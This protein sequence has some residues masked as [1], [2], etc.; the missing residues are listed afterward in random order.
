[1]YRKLAYH[2]LQLHIFLLIQRYFLYRLLFNF[3]DSSSFIGKFVEIVTGIEHKYVSCHNTIV[4][5]LSQ[6]SVGWPRYAPF[7]GPWIRKTF[8]RIWQF[9][10]Y[11]YWKSLTMEQSV[12]WAVCIY[13]YYWNIIGKADICA[14]KMARRLTPIVYNSV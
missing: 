1:M 4:L 7:L 11:N 13:R 2:V 5:F 12:G 9:F 3:L 14:K 6:T 10:K 8:N